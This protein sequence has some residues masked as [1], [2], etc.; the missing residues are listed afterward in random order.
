MCELKLATGVGSYLIVWVGG[1]R[2]NG[3]SEN[4]PMEM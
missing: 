1:E 2:A 3:S 4:V